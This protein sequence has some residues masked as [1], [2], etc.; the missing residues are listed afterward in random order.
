MRTCNIIQNGLG[1]RGASPC[2]ANLPLKWSQIATLV[3][4]DKYLDV[5]KNALGCDL[6]TA[7]SWQFLQKSCCFSQRNLIDTC[8]PLV[9]MF[10]LTTVFVTNGNI[11]DGSGN[12][13]K[14]KQQ[15]V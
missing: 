9:K 5:S 12:F 2:E 7:L 13:W 15:H 11:S 10:P 6:D 3:A 14:K 8:L 1:R 4:I